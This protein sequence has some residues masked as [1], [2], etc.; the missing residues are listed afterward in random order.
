MKDYLIYIINKYLGMNSETRER[1]IF[2]IIMAIVDFLSAFNIIEFTDTQIQAIYKL[3]LVIITAIVWA[4]CSHYKNNDYTEAATIGT[5]ITR[6][7]KLEQS[8]DYI[9]ERFYTNEDGSLLTEDCSNF[10]VEE[11]D[12]DTMSAEM[13]A[14]EMASAEQVSD[15]LE[16]SE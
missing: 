12:E 11:E 9:G 2:A 4:Y 16:E 5:G 15:E 8:E 1:T 13:L 6:Q 10:Y 7:I 3:V 14:A